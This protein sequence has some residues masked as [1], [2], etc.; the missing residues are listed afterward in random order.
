MANQNND[1]ILD[2]RDICS[3]PK[4]VIHEGLL[5]K[6]LDTQFSKPPESQFNQETSKISYTLK[7]YSIQ[8]KILNKDYKNI[9]KIQLKHDKQSYFGL[10]LCLAQMGNKEVAV[11]EVNPSLRKSILQLETEKEC[12][13]IPMITFVEAKYQKL[14]DQ[15]QIWILEIH[16]IEDIEDNEK[17]TLEE[18]ELK[19]K[20]LKP[21]AAQLFKESKFKEA[22]QIYKI[23]FSKIGQIPK[24][25]KNKMTEEQKTFF[26]IELSRVFSNQAICF[27]Q[28]NDF[29]KAIETSKQAIQV[30]DENFK[31]HFIYAKAHLGTGQES[32]A[33]QLFQKIA[34]KFPNEDLTEVQKYLQKTQKNKTSKNEQEFYKKIFEKLPEKDKDEKEREIRD[35][36]EKVEKNRQTEKILVQ[37]KNGQSINHEQIQKLQ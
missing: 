19:I 10:H 25:Q 36:F 5:W 16:D 17:L 4:I 8:G 14:L 31:A 24:I 34:Q 21:Q 1:S 23:L 30:W 11:F 26:K 29:T 9:R 6:Y 32:E 27:L 3:K 22:I 33:F 7:E 13:D 18:R 15:P 35:K 20:I 28:I 2:F 12:Q 37:A